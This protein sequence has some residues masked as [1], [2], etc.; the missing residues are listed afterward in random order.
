MNQGILAIKSSKTQYSEQEA[1]K[2]LGVTVEELRALIRS[3]IA[4]SDEDLNNVA[5]ASFHPSDLLILKLLSGVKASPTVP[6]S[7]A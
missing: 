1:A 6:D 7:E 4:E 5:V 3:H 2:E